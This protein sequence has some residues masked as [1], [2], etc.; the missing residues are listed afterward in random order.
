MEFTKEVILKA[1]PM[2]VYQAWLDSEAHTRMTG[3]EAQC[4]D[5][6]GADFTAWDGYISGKNLEL[7]P[8][9]KI[10]QSWRTTQFKANEPDSLLTI[11]F[12]AVG[13]KTKLV[14]HHS[15]VP[16]DGGH[17]I[18]GWEHHY[19]EPMKQYFTKN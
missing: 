1:T 19:F 13:D 10:V 14:L 2:E 4:S 3:G 8:H 17:Y 6:Q 7:I 9:Q 15:N 16:E 12:E 5:Q 18:Q 11:T